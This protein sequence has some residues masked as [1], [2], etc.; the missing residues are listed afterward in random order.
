M[1][2]IFEALSPIRSRSVTMREMAITRRRSRAVGCRRA[3]SKVQSS[4]MPTSSRVHFAVGVDDPLHGLEISR[5]ESVSC[6]QQLSFDQTTHLQDAGAN[7]FEF[8]VE[9][10]AEM[11]THRDSTRFGKSGWIAE[12]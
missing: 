11:I 12:A 10:F 8:E 5:P 2:A 3:I 6:R 1:L 7:V 9:L 4:S